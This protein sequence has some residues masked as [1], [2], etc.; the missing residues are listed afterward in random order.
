MKTLKNLG[1][2]IMPPT[3]I[4]ARPFQVVDIDNEIYYAAEIS[5]FR[6]FWL[7]PIGVIFALTEIDLKNQLKTLYNCDH[8][9]ERNLKNFVSWYE[10][11]TNKK[12]SNKEVKKVVDK[13]VD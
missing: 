1:I 2:E 13:F 10:N 8:L 12:L 9:M 11:I 6:D 4:V 5:E 7:E 3:K